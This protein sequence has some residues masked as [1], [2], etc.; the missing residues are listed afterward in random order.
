M[1]APAMQCAFEG[2][3]TG[4]LPADGGSPDPRC[5]ILVGSR[6]RTIF[7]VDVETGGVRWVHPDDGEN[8]NRRA[9]F[10]KD[11]RSPALLQREAYA[12]PS[13]KPTDVRSTRTPSKPVFVPPSS[14]RSYPAGARRRRGRS[15]AEGAGSRPRRGVPR[16]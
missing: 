5:G 4:L 12:L 14:G 8:A 13:G 10:G 11:A 15:R 6:D 3:P 16:G 2:G 9:A 7:G 1:D